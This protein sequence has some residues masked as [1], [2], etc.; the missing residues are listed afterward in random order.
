M[1]LPAFSITLKSAKGPAFR[2][3][4]PLEL[5]PRNENRTP[6]SVIS[7]I[8]T[9]MHNSLYQNGFYITARER[10]K[11]HSANTAND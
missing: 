10:H 8:V 7:T 2:R 6:Y 1:V 5:R 4:L 9:E 3:I 11:L